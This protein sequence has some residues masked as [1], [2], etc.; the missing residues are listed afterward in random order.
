[1]A[2]AFTDSSHV[3]IIDT[4]TDQPLEGLKCFESIENA[5]DFL[6]WLEAKHEAGLATDRDPRKLTPSYRRGLFGRWWEE[7]VDKETG[8][9]LEAP[10]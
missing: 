2:L 4:V 3:A 9:L 1:M 10:A 8:L 7:R 5:Q 6:E